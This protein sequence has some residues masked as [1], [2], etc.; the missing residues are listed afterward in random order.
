MKKSNINEK[1]RPFPEYKENEI[2]K[3]QNGIIQR[4][5]EKSSQKNELYHKTK[6]YTKS[7]SMSFRSP[8]PHPLLLPRLHHHLHHHPHPLRHLH[9]HHPP[10]RPLHLAY[11][12][13]Q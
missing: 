9:R 6:Q 8:H 7:P 2:H 13:T 12:D 4:K 3:K 10:N 11:P 1:I 5:K